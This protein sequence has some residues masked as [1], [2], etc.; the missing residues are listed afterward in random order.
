MTGDRAGLPPEVLVATRNPGKLHELRPMFAALGIAIVDLASAG[1]PET[2]DEEAIEA[3]A[4]FEENALAKARHFH[5]VTGRAA[6]AD[7]S[8]LE[9][10]ALDG[11]PGVRSKGFSGVS[12]PDREVYAANNA[13]LVRKLQGVADRRARF[14]CAA[15]YV[16]ATRELV[17]RGS[18]DG[19]IVDVAAGREGF[20]YDPHFHSTELGKTFAEA[21]REE[22]GAISHRGRAFAAL[23]RA[24]A[25]GERGGGGSGAASGELSG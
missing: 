16:D 15:A 22:K 4:T 20:G 6:V 24:L 13:L 9:V 19:L 17:R 18:A 10:R 21:T 8:G 1:V 14:V 3:F 11:A 23:A 5:R 2:A 25:D 7:D 12:G